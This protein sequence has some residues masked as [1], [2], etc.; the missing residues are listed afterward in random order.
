MKETLGIK[1]EEDK[2]KE[3]EKTTYVTFRP[4]RGTTNPSQ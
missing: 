1:E 2:H 4:I 3:R